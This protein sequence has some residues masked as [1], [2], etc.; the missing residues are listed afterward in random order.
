MINQCF[1]F[2]RSNRSYLESEDYPNQ[3]YV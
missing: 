1:I 2:V 3:R